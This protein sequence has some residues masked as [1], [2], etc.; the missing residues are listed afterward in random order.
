M[1][2]ITPCVAYPVY[3]LYS[4][5]PLLLLCTRSG[6]S[7]ISLCLWNIEQEDD[8]DDV[9]LLWAMTRVDVE[10]ERERER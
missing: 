9:E 6:L 10:E 5:L 8:D 1:I 4:L 3:L 7:L 2:M